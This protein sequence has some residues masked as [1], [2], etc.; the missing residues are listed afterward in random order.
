MRIILT[1]LGK[2]EIAKNNIRSN[3]VG[4]LTRDKA[5]FD[6]VNDKSKDDI[7][8]IINNNI[9]FNKNRNNIIKLY[10]IKTKFKSQITNKNK[11]IIKNLSLSTK[12]IKNNNNKNLSNIITPRYK[13]VYLKKKDLKIPPDIEM[14]YSKDI[15][16][17][18]LK[19]FD[20]NETNSNN[21]NNIINKKEICSLSEGNNNINNTNNSNYNEEN[22]YRS[23]N[24]IRLPLIKLKK[25]LPIKDIINN[26]IKCKIKK[27]LL[28]KEINQ[29]E[30]SL[31]KYLKLDKKITP[32]F[33]E[34]IYKADCGKI[35]HINKVCAHYFI[36]EEKNSFIQNKIKNKIELKKRKKLENCKKNLRNMSYELNNYKKIC[37]YLIEKKESLKEAKAFFLK[38]EFLKYNFYKKK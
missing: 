3:S 35:S 38:H 16:E 17:T 27:E 6:F 2:E 5:L 37:K 30:T 25:L 18:K 15:M 28:N 12:L 22:T 8:H 1:S 23:F 24:S 9:I 13:I 26:N 31:I 10:K 33:L 36:N 20:L 29:K 32:F 4:N 19:K 21:I 34:K 14:K 7:N 11:H